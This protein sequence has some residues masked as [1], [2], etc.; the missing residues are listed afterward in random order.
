MM[1]YAFGVHEEIAHVEMDLSL[2]DA[3]AWRQMA[4]Q[5]RSFVHAP[6]L[7]AFWSEFSCEVKSWHEDGDA[8]FPA[9]DCLAALD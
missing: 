5:G 9:Q 8:P 7:L 2:D 3:L 4:G 1:I 6:S